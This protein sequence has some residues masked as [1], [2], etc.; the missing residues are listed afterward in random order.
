MQS[1]IAGKLSI[2]SALATC[3]LSGIVYLLALALPV[4]NLANNDPFYG[5]M[6]LFLGWMGPFVNDAGNPIGW[7]ANLFLVFGWGAML[8]GKFR[9]LAIAAVIAL[10]LGLGI[11]LT[12]FGVT[13]LPVN[14]A[15]MVARVTIGAGVYAWLASFAIALLGSIAT[16]V[17][18]FITAK[19]AP[20]KIA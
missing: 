4:Y 5:I 8:L 10:V 12:S 11:A 2:L 6:V 17:L 18:A 1:S 19:R 14:E 13:R 15:G 9:P 20:Q 16:A 7:Y 3:V